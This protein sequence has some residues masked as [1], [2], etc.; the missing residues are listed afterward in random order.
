MQKESLDSVVVRI[1]LIVDM[2]NFTQ[3]E[4]LKQEIESH[5]ISVE[6]IKI[7]GYR[8]VKKKSEVNAVATFGLQDIN[9][10][11][12]F[13]KEELNEFVDEEFDLLISYYD[14]EKSFLLFLTHR[15][16]AKFKVGFSSV[17]TRLN[18][19]LINI[20]QENF[21]GFV[22]ELFRYLKILNKI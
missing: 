10:K 7:I 18:H 11:S 17:D 16:K 19:L 20:D 13:T 3:T 1:G 14:Y 8:D 12:E 9:F 5:G 21:K 4:A 15:S 6:N 22:N 2:S